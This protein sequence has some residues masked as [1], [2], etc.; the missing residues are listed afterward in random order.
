MLNDYFADKKDLKDWDKRKTIAKFMHQAGWHAEAKKELDDLVEEYPSKKDDVADLRTTVKKVQADIYVEDIE[1]AYKAGQHR[2]V[3]D[4]LGVFARESMGPLVSEKNLLLVEDIKNKYAGA[5]E[6]LAEAKG[7]LSAILKR[8]SGSEKSVWAT[9]VDTILAELN[10]DT[11]GR[12]ENFVV[13][14]QQHQ[15]ELDDKGTAAQAA[16][17]VPIVGPIRLAP[18]QR[19]R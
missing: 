11:L 4:R 17:E 19:L 9:A 14:A 12:L 6:K 2:E 8:V 15:R 18:G 7:L 3:E 16:D 5:N 10:L 13:F 1:R